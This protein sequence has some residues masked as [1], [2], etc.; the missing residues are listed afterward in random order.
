MKKNLIITAIIGL[1]LGTANAQVKTTVRKFPKGDITIAPN[2]GQ[3]ANSEKLSVWGERPYG[4]RIE[5]RIA[6]DVFMQDDKIFRES[7]VMAGKTVFVYGY[8]AQKPG[9]LSGYW[10]VKEPDI[11]EDRDMGQ[12]GRNAYITT[13]GDYTVY[14]IAQH[15]M[16]SYR[17]GYYIDA[18]Y[19]AGNSAF[20]KGLVITGNTVLNGTEANPTTFDGE[21]VVITI[22]KSILR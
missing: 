10:D 17:L 7:H 15:G 11:D 4:H 9:E 1:V 3:K 6:N 12:A 14:R 20:K 5:V 8:H 18:N 13:E 16:A 2:N 19:L 22:S 21:P